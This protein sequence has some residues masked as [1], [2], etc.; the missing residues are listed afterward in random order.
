[1]EKYS[2][3]EINQT[4]IKITI[5]ILQ[6]GNE[7][8]VFIYLFNR[9][10]IEYLS[11][12]IVKNVLIAK[13]NKDIYVLNSYAEKDNALQQTDIVSED[14]S[15]IIKK[16]NNVEPASNLDLVNIIYQNL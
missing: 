14:N 4:T 1:M 10:E 7:I 8:P 16:I 13:I 12:D 15:F 9:K 11:F 2:K 5:C 6:E 3:I